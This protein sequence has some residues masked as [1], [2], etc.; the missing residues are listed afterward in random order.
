MALQCVVLVEVENMAVMDA[1]VVV[2]GDVSVCAC[3][4]R[5]DR[6]PSWC[7]RIIYGDIVDFVH[8]DLT[9]LGKV[10]L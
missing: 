5:R 4:T 6:S 8:D 1:A 2:G 9:Y 7:W 10:M 3:G